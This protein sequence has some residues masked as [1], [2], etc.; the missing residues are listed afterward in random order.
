MT[1]KTQM[2][3]PLVEVSKAPLPTAHKWIQPVVRARFRSLRDY[4]TGVTVWYEIEEIG[5]STETARLVRY[6]RGPLPQ[7]FWE[8]QPAHVREFPPD[9]IKQMFCMHRE[10]FTSCISRVEDALMDDYLS[11]NKDWL[12]SLKE[13]KREKPQPI[14]LK[15]REFVV[16]DWWPDGLD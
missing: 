8:D 7:A 10:P 12:A 6:V 11:E 13:V 5:S 9:I 14:S 1:R 16:K 4:P 3:P 2:S 15:P